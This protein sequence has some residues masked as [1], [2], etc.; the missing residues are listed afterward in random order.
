ML[1]YEEGDE[2]GKSMIMYVAP[3]VIYSSVFL[4]T[5]Y[6]SSTLIS[7]EDRLTF[8]DYPA[9]SSANLVNSDGVIMLRRV[10]HPMQ[11]SV[12]AGEICKYNRERRG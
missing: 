4:H 5:F 1:L 8:L 10:K 2:H 7:S 9:C 3:C 6:M 11:N 12:H